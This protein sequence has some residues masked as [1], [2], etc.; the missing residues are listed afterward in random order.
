MK[1]LYFEKYTAGSKALSAIKMSFLIS[2]YPIV[3]SLTK[4]I[5]FD[6]NLIYYPFNQYYE[7]ICFDDSNGKLKNDKLPTISVKFALQ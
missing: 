7:Y 1:K 3:I 5:E 2:A 4:T 6:Q